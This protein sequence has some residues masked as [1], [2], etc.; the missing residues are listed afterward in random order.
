MNIRERM[1][2]VFNCQK[3][4]KVPFYSFYGPNTQLIP[5]GSFERKIRNRGLGL[6]TIASPISSEMPN[7][8]TTTRKTDISEETT[9]HTPIGDVST[10]SYGK[11]NRITSPLWPVKKKHLFKNSKDYDPI[12]Y[13][14][15]DTIYHIDLEEFKLKDQDVGEDGILHVAMVL[16][17][18]TQT[19]DLMGLE[20]WCYEQNDNPG[21]FSNLLDALNKRSNTIINLLVEIEDNIHIT[22]GDIRDG[23]NPDSYLKYEIPIYE[24]A[25]EALRAG[26]KKCG[27]HAHSSL[28]K[29]QKKVLARMNPDYIEAYT[30]PPY[31]D[32]PLPELREAV[33]EDT[34]ILINFPET[35]FYNG[36]EKTRD[37]TIELLKS[38]PSYNKMIGFTE[39]GMMG[40]DE[41]TRSV[42]EDGIIAILDAIDELE[43]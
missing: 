6:L 14:I 1:N 22:C 13:M 31:S 25:F 18:F 7:I 33:G 20:K 27:I 40:V 32:L 36:Y 39:M 15:K 10:E 24:K 30:P 21:K 38:D 26:G 17:P 35:I 3:P 28:L 29:N 16:P 34:S 37:Y 43:Y 5:S 23:V 4:D 19:W 11:T 42:F 12:I 9:Y 2:A 41:R 8:S